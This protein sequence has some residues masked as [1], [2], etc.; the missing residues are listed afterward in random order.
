MQKSFLAKN[1]ILGGS[2]VLKANSVLLSC[3]HG[4][5]FR[6]QTWAL[7]SI[8]EPVV[9]FQSEVFAVEK[10]CQIE[11]AFSKQEVS[12]KLGFDEQKKESNENVGKCEL[13]FFLKTTSLRLV[14]LNTISNLTFKSSLN[15]LV[16]TSFSNSSNNNKMQVCAII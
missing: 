4:S 9:Q 2:L 1:V 10:S 15:L 3:F 5:N 8:N 6:A 14:H 12:I 7:F 16:V 11:R 13:L